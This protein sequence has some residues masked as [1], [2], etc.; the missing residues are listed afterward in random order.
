[1][2]II[3]VTVMLF[4]GCTTDQTNDNGETE[5][6]GTEPEDCGNDVLNVMP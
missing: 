3:F 5:Q 1:M 4:S 2:S 6:N